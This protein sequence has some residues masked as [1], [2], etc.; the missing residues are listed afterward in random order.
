MSNP[1]HSVSQGNQLLTSSSPSDQSFSSLT[2]A[3]VDQIR[4]SAMAQ[5]ASS[6][7]SS[8]KHHALEADDL[9]SSL[10]DSAKEKPDGWTM[11]LLCASA[12]VALTGLLFYFL[13]RLNGS[14][15]SSWGLFITPNSV[16]SIMITLIECLLCTV[17]S[18]RIPL[19][20]KAAIYDALYGYS[21]TCP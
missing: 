15:V 13:F 19:P 10:M 11:E 14:P 8:K 16:I 7:Q 17:L 12:A 9:A 18:P 2:I 5:G 3:F 6:E 20:M 1:N 21:P 4:P